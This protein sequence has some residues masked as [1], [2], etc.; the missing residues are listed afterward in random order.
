MGLR[1]SPIYLSAAALALATA[2]CNWIFGISEGQLEATGGSGGGTTTATTT[3]TD[4]TSSMGGAGGS[5][6]MPDTTTTTTAA[7]GGGG[8][9]GGGAPAC[10]V[11]VGT[12]VGTGNKFRPTNADYGDWATGAAFD[13][14]GN[15]VVVGNFEN[16]TIDLGGG[17]LSHTPKSDFY[18]QNVFVAKYDSAYGYV[19]S[20]VFGG[21]Q[22][23]QAFGI[24]TAPDGSIWITG[25][26][27]GTF[28]AAGMT[29]TYEH[30]MGDPFYEDMF[31][32]KLDPAGNALWAKRFGNQYIQS[33]MA[34]SVDS[35]GNG[36]I[37]GAGW[38]TM[39]FGTGAPFG[40]D[41]TWSSYLLKLDPDG[42]PLWVD[43]HLNYTNDF[44]FYPEPNR[45][46]VV[47]VDKDDQP[48]L[49][50]NFEAQAYFGDEIIAPFGGA[51]AY[52]LKLDNATGAV[53]WKT[54]IHGP[55]G[56]D[57]DQFATAITTDPCTGHIYVA[58]G[59]K[60][61]IT[62]AGTTATVSIGD[63]N[64]E[65]MFLLKLDGATGDPLWLKTFGD[66]GQQRIWSLN[67]DP[68]GNVVMVG[69]L[70]DA[71]GYVGVDFGPGIGV[72]LPSPAPV[73]PDYSI[74]MFV[75]KLDADGN[76]IWG[77]RL[78]DQYA[79]I[80][81]S[82]DTNAAGEIGIAGEFDG[83]LDLPGPTIPP[84]FSNSYDAFFAWMKP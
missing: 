4:S 51:D 35:Q 29:L 39:D 20:G 18:D 76:G 61:A 13:A 75:V 3:T 9:G 19:W 17:A 56:S 37:S 27:V 66:A 79:Q 46:I 40:N 8:A 83:S 36:F 41:S 70:Q 47:A 62:A 53:S 24:A 77:Y 21:S 23:A 82:V 44:A 52:V 2:S 43:S 16:D 68:A 32:L 84:Y 25:R 60:G 45:E 55:D 34:V 30:V 65:D 1:T 49:A 72:K 12:P 38:H 73:D 6:G 7:Q 58:G 14:T 80:G 31:V 48:V 5:G 74:D 57:G 33:G 69:E 22:A 42:T 28:E 64:A 54:F 78:G 67:V 26:F 63:P 10:Y 59:F 50:G 81:W 71:A 15:L 11:D